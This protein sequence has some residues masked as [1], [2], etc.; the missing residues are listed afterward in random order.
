[1]LKNNIRIKGLF[2]KALDIIEQVSVASAA[3]FLSVSTIKIDRTFPTAAIGKVGQD[4]IL[5]VNPE[6][7]AEFAATPL[8]FAALLLHEIMHHLLG[9]LKERDSDIY[10]AYARDAVINASI[11]RL[12]PM[13]E[14]FFKDVYSGEKMP[15]KF[16]RPQSLINYA[17]TEAIHRYAVLWLPG[18]YG[19][20]KESDD[21]YLDEIYGY[22]DFFRRKSPL[23]NIKGTILLGSHGPCAG[24]E[25]EGILIPQTIAAAIK[26]E[27]LAHSGQKNR[28]Y[29]ERVFES[30]L[31]D[32]LSAVP[33]AELQIAKNELLKNA[34]EKVLE[35]FG[36]RG[37]ESERTVFP[38]SDISR[39]EL[40]LFAAGIYPAYFSARKSYRAYKEA[41]VYVDVSG[42]MDNE[43]RF[44]Y[45]LLG[46]LREYLAPKVFN[47]SNKVVEVAKDD[48][49]KGKICSTGG[50]DFNCVCEHF[51]SHKAKKALII[52]DGYACVEESLAKRVM[53][54]KEMTAVVTCEESDISAL[55]SF[56]R[57][58][59]RV[60]L[61]P[62]DN[63]IHGANEYGE[64]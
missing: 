47:F 29:C 26:K 5:F 55:N 33:A 50:T 60:N 44:V 13:F 17:D 40:S 9:H 53:N 56:C 61:S 34:I 54:E 59:V 58:V 16:L 31:H 32:F 12:S 21:S 15:A 10:R 39:R 4:N 42:S 27:L 38:S 11:C 64:I 36:V 30:D 23:R 1:M 45:S 46:E 7:T 63:S 22:G 37:H 52:T 48:F 62:N 14:P 28:G 25:E 6:F 49:L 57:K 35:V 51:I 41:F 3:D 2:R 24:E 19:K 18:I 8:K 43:L 20:A